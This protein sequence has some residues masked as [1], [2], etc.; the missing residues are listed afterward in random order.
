MASKVVHSVFPGLEVGTTEATAG[1]DICD[2]TLPLLHAGLEFGI[3][4]QAKVLIEMI[5]PVECPLL[6]CLLLAADEVMCF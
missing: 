4:H 2:A 6:Y 1:F 5:L 3:V